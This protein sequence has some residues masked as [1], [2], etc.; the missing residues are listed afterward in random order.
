MIAEIKKKWET[1]ATSS[2]GIKISIPI[3][4]GTKEEAEDRAQWFCDSVK[5]DTLGIITATYS[6]KEAAPC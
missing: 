3:Y 5:A 4:Y 2:D 1:I 6:I